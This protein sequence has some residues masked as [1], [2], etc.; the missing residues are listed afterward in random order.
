M[1]ALVSGGKD[2]TLALQEAVEAGH[3]PVA[4]ATAAPASPGEAG[5]VLSALFQTAGS[6]AVPLLAR[7]AN[8]PL[9]RAPALTH[10]NVPDADEPALLALAL[11]CAS[12]FG[13]D[14]L[15]CGAVLSDYQRLRVERACAA[16][17]I[18]S[19]APLWQRSQAQILRDVSSHGFHA[20]LVRVA[21]FGLDPHIHL[22][23]RLD[24]ISER[25]QHISDSY[26]VH[27]SGEGG[28]YETLVLDS[29]SH[30]H[31]FGRIELDSPQPVKAGHE[32]GYL[33][34][35]SARYI[36]KGEEHGDPTVVEVDVS[37][38]GQTLCE[39]RAAP[40]CTRTPNT[41]R[42]L[43][44]TL[45]HLK[46]SDAIAYVFAQSSDD[47]A[48]RG[49]MEEAVST[50]ITLRR[51]LQAH[52]LD[53]NDCLLLGVF[54]P[55]MDLFADI[56]AAFGLCVPQEDGA[57]PARACIQSNQQRITMDAFV[58]PRAKTEPRRRSNVH[59]SSISKWAPACIG[60]YAQCTAVGQLCLLAGQIGLEPFSM[61]LTEQPAKRA[62]DPRT[63]AQAAM[64]LKHCCAIAEASGFDFRKDCAHMYLFAR[65]ERPGPVLR[66]ALHALKDELTN[67]MVIAA[68]VSGLPRQA[69]VE[70]QPVLLRGCRRT[71]FLRSTDGSGEVELE[72]CA[73]HT[74]D[75]QE[76]SERWHRLVSSDA[77]DCGAVRV[78][79]VAAAELDGIAETLG[80]VAFCHSRALLRVMWRR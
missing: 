2:S 73:G 40:P 29:N 46:G 42:L 79:F 11:R 65:E 69:S 20:V 74:N 3:E 54:V 5:D 37:A 35:P 53:W 21:S 32:D 13:A 18:V 38:A 6:T 76:P 58:C 19:L 78:S 75:A 1:A 24:D 15:V 16:A 49:V 33:R 14:A 10:G 52:S 12:D 25:L 68:G 4:L 34:I 59:I 9:V 31:R 77:D 70:L 67:C 57:A 60:P 43:K 36:A 50:L 45:D 55:N 61:Q 80:S 26:G 8:L 71:G 39:A 44:S 72:V 47:A 51:A 17:N 62:E 64:A 66:S 30:M 28:E 41:G 7:C 63:C 56:N 23:R 27:R 22:G 48:S